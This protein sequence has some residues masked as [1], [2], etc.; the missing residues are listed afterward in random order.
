M[1]DKADDSDQLALL[2]RSVYS[3]PSTAQSTRHFFSNDIARLAAHLSDEHSTLLMGARVFSFLQATDTCNLTAWSARRRA[4]ALACISSQG[5]AHSL[6]MAVGYTLCSSM[7]MV[8]NKLALRLFPFPSM[9]MALQFSFSALV[10]PHFLSH[11]MRMNNA[12]S[13]A[14]HSLTPAFA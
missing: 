7:L 12:L 8:S 1:A 9:L 11:R 13:Y 10:H 6:P 2:I 4:H 14:A 5:R 3:L